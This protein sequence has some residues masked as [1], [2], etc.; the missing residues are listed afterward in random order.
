[1]FVIPAPE[2]ASLFWNNLKEEK[3]YLLQHSVAGKGG[4]FKS[5][6]STVQNMLSTRPSPFRIVFRVDPYVDN[7]I[8]IAVGETRDEILQ[9]WEWVEKDTS[10]I[11]NNREMREA[12]RAFRQAFDLGQDER[13]VSYYSCS[14]D[15]GIV[16]QG[17]LYLSENYLCFYSFLL[18]RETKLCIEL[19]NIEKLTKKSTMIGI[20]EDGIEIATKNGEVTLFT[21]LFHRD[22]TYDLIK[23]LCSNAAKLVLQNSEFTSS[24]HNDD[25]DVAHA[26]TVKGALKAMTDGELKGVSK[27]NGMPQRS[28]RNLAEN[29]KQQKRDEAYHIEFDLPNTES[30]LATINNAGL[31]VPGRV[32]IYAGTLYISTSFVAFSSLDYRGCKFTLPL[33][34]IQRIERLNSRDPVM[35]PGY[36]LIITVWHKMKIQFYIQPRQLECDRWCHALRLRLKFMMDSQKSAKVDGQQS[37]RYALKAFLATC[38]SEVLLS[39]VMTA[40]ESADSEKAQ[41][42]K[43]KLLDDK[44][45]A[46]E[47]AKKV[48]EKAATASAVSNVTPLNPQAIGKLLEDNDSKIGFLG[49]EFGF[50]VA[51]DDAKEKIKLR[52]W[53][54]YMTEQGR[55]LTILRKADFSALVRK[56]LPNRL[57]GEIWEL[58]SGAMYLRFQ[59]QNIYKGLCQKLEADPELFSDEIEKDLNRSLPEYPAYQSEKGINVLRRVL[60]AYSL[61]NP[62]LG[63][64]QAMNIVASALLI[65]A[66]EEQVFWI[67]SSMCD[68]LVSGYYTPS[69]YGATVDQSVFEYLVKETMPM[70]DAQF[71]K[72]DIQ[73]S[74]ACLPWFLT[75]FINSMPLHLAMRVLD[76][77]FLEGPKI[78]FQIG[79]ATLKINGGELLQSSDDGMFIF[80]LKTYFQ[81]L[82]EPVNPT[83]N[84]AR[85]SQITRF[86]ELLAVAYRDF[87][88]VTSNLVEELRQA[89]RL[90]VVHTVSDFTKRTAIRNLVDQGGF[91]Q[92]QLNIL[93]DSFYEALFYSQNHIEKD[94]FNQ[95][96]FSQQ[97]GA[98]QIKM[99]LVTFMLF[100]SNLTTWAQADI[101]EAKRRSKQQLRNTN[102]LENP[103]EKGGNTK[104]ENTLTGK[105]NL[106]KQLKETFSKPGWFISRLFRYTNAIVPPTRIYRTYQSPAQSI[107]SLDSSSSEGQEYT[108]SSNQSSDGAEK[109]SSPQQNMESSNLGGT[110]S[111]SG[112]DKPTYTL[113]ERKEEWA[114]HQPLESLRVSFAQCVIALGRL[115]NTD[116]MTR[117]DML[118][119]LY[120][121]DHIGFLNWQ[122]LLYLSDAIPYLCRGF[123]EITQDDQ[124][125]SPS[126]KPDHELNLEEQLISAMSN[127]VK[128]WMISY[129]KYHQSAEYEEEDGSLDSSKDMQPSKNTAPQSHNDAKTDS[130]LL[131]KSLFRMLVLEDPVLE[132]FFERILPN[133]F[134]LNPELLRVS[135]GKIPKLASN[136]SSTSSTNA[137]QRGQTASTP[138]S[139]ASTFGQS[140]LSSGKLFASNVS[141][142]MSSG[143]SMGSQFV[144]KNILS[145]VVLVGATSEIAKPTVVSTYAPQTIVADSP[146]KDVKS[147]RTGKAATT[148]PEPQEPYPEIPTVEAPGHIQ[149]DA[150]AQ[151]IAKPNAPLEPYD[152][153]MEE[154]DELLNELNVQDG[155]DS[156]GKSYKN[157][158]ESSN[159]DSITTPEGRKSGGSATGLLSPEHRAS[160][161]VLSN[162]EKKPSFADFDIEDE[163]L[164]NILD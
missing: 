41:D 12:T 103:K 15:K 88:M 66:T 19:R 126:E 90:K 145:P 33:A 83:A 29:L 91:T 153:V 14:L 130:M 141:K 129:S 156:I 123:D 25:Q 34:A 61:Q 164:D 31:I 138:L 42:E 23:Q 35:R 85:S 104:S 146:D 151:K 76:C 27:N 75:L 45:N 57:R 24:S 49:E 132:S 133:S 59:N 110:S 131:N 39:E 152:G 97:S 162:T 113:S 64:C 7:F 140:L 158:T 108:K 102:T 142:S 120:D 9:D 143:I 95:R 2:G 73:L 48:S 70:L 150:D 79:L 32:E 36:E 67:L 77:F 121:I 38:A 127:L 163:D 58:T 128:R 135:R 43:E 86:H 89:H 18:D 21:N 147:G 56:G 63:Y 105:S 5:M 11:G 68:R 44:G 125:L 72:A 155:F 52:R 94:K 106:E 154:V 62:N 8:V 119:K 16:N 144:D 4:L 137:Q 115:M 3:H 26:N 82:D 54:N 55:N 53:I 80:T 100:L 114:D 93:Y 51:P 148:V 84:N 160:S 20:R 111:A 139:S 96:A 161:E 30:V 40:S 124:T 101:K 71:K 118:F 17:W 98:E 47:T 157:N 60:N 159:K 1:M 6:L 107:K 81:T 149:G 65:Y 28:V 74:V 22:E 69:M 109:V 134:G 99:D 13:L 92:S 78:L 112:K 37:G 46:Y 87:P 116:I 50:P 10:N 117:I 122:N 136:R